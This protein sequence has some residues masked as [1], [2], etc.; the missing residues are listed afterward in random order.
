MKPQLYEVGPISEEDRASVVE[1]IRNLLSLA[2][3]GKIIGFAAVGIREDSAPQLWFSTEW[4]HQDKLIGALARAQFQ[5]M[6]RWSA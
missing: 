1:S 3:E 6:N 5:L 2:E 4:V